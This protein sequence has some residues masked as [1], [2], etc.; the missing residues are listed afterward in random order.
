[1]TF[2]TDQQPDSRPRL[3]AVGVDIIEIS[4]I[5]AFRARGAR[6]L[7][8]IFTPRELA[9][10]EGRGDPDQFLAARFAAKEAVAKCI[11]PPLSWHDVEVLSNPDG[12]PK[13]VLSG[14]ASAR[15][16]SGTVL[17]SLSHCR[18]YAVAFAVLQS[19]QPGE[20]ND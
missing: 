11:G 13:V 2:P 14:R 1:M 18:D 9:V 17:I 12:S 8:R 4:R 6:Y 3:A 20:P 16:G 7:E 19:S 10:A 15:A 5:A